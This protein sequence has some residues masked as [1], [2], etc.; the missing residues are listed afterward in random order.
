[1]AALTVQ[2]IAA[3]GVTP[4]YGSANGGGDTMADDGKENNFLHVK[5]GGGGSINVTIA[6]V[7]TS[8]EVPGYGDLTVSNMVV[9]V[10]AGAEAMI[11]PFPRAYINSSGNVAITYSGVTSV[12]IGAFKLARPVA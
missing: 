9:A 8:K 1:M 5:N 4:S 10:G 12:T 7:N 11:G 2:T 3:A 6:A